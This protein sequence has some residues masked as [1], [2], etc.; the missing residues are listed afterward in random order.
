MEQ[1]QSLPASSY[2]GKYLRISSYT[3][4][5]SPSSYRYDFVTAPLRISLYMRKIGFFFFIGAVSLYIFK[6][7]RWEQ[8]YLKECLQISLCRYKK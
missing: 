7:D 8:I 5:G 2:M 3:V 1:L 4:L 6:K